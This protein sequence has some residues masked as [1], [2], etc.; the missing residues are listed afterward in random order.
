MSLSPA[1]HRRGAAG[2]AAIIMLVIVQLIVVGAVLAV[3]RDS[4]IMTLR[5][6]TVRAFYAAEAGANMAIREAMIGVD[7]DGDGVMGS[8]SND[9][10]SSNDP[11]LVSAR[12]STTPS[13]AG[14]TT[15]IVSDGR[16]GLA[17]RRATAQ[18]TGL[19]GSSTQTVMA[20]W[21]RSGSSI[22][23]YSVWGGSS[24]S[25]AQTMPAMAGEAKWVRMK[26]CPTRN[27]TTFIQEDLN[28]HVNVCFYNG[29]TWG[30]VS[31]LSS[32]TGG[33]NDRPEDIAYEQLSSNALCVY[34]KGTSHL[35]GYRTYNGMT[36]SA[37]QTFTSPFTTEDDFLTLCPRPLTNDILALA[38]DGIA[39]LSLQ[40]K[41]WSNGAWGPWVTMVPTLDNN[42]QECYAGAF[43][44]QTGRDVRVTNR[45]CTGAVTRDVMGESSREIGT[46]KAKPRV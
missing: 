39:G 9:G 43:E 37:E 5:L 13:V 20:A 40:A 45:A 24:W 6:D 10:D 16:C 21:T 17:R 28:K 15:S 30:T 7:E 19:I 12:V 11:L 44:A 26:I 31:L 1:H 29:S 42:N 23:R 38:A 3:T 14:N 46:P 36:F 18:V 27:E 2:V 8:I 25:A 41:L 33:T 4:S 35:F 34:W 32:D 22:P